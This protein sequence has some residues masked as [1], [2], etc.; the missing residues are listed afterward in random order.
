MVTTEN[1]DPDVPLCEQCCF[2]NSGK[3]YLPAMI[4]K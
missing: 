2:D 3:S 1:D 4:G